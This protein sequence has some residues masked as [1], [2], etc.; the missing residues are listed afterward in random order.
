[1]PVSHMVFGAEMFLPNQRPKPTFRKKAEHYVAY[2]ALHVIYPVAD[3]QRG[4]WGPGPQAPGG[5]GPQAPG[6]PPNSQ[7][8]IF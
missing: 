1:M 7:Q 2:N 6:G 5:P 3:Q 4:H 8:T